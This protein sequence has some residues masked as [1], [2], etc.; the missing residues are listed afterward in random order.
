LA[1]KVSSLLVGFLVLA[2]NG[3]LKPSRYFKSGAFEAITKGLMD[4]VLG[5][6]LCEFHWYAAG[7]MLIGRSLDM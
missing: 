1:S 2:Y 5:F 4:N 6:A 3:Q 7:V